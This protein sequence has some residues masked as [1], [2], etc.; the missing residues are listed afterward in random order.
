MLEQASD[1]TR[2]DPLAGGD[3]ECRHVH[4]SLSFGQVSLRYVGHVEKPLL[5]CLHGWLDNS[6]SFH[7]LAKELVDDYQL[8]LVDLPGHGLS[9]PLKEGSHYYIWQ[10][11]EV[12]YELLGVLKLDN[13][14]FLAHSMGGVA[15]SLFAGSFP[16]KV[17]RLILLDSIGPMAS[18]PS[19]AA[20]Q[21]AKSIQ[22]E[23]QSNPNLRTFETV[24]HA[25]DAR[26]KASPK[27][28]NAG[29]L[30]IVVRNLKVVDG[31]YSWS[32]DKRLRQTS[33]V[34][35][36]E[37]QVQGFFSAITANVLALI[38]EEGI[39]PISWREHRLSLIPKHQSFV[40]PGHHHFHCEIQY[41]SAISD[42][43]KQFMTKK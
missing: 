5:I 26:K 19:N 33:K 30:P 24:E 41:A 42:H 28:S 15:A 43:I 14:S 38:A 2:W 10:Y 12:L 36:T 37:E 16:E 22:Q 3:I 32:T 34:S 6:S 40:L 9:D 25:L 23:Q 18:V 4:V 11:V 17:E 39:I 20:S 27:M 35:L 21:L 13:A 8:L 7:C 31:G 1:L 29:L